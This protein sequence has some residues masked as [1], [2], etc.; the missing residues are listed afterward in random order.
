MKIELQGAGVAV[1][2]AFL[3]K[4]VGRMFFALKKVVSQ[5]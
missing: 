3:K 5:I 4:T 2:D 1:I